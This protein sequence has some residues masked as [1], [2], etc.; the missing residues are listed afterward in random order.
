MQRKRQPN[1]RLE[2]ERILARLLRVGTWLGTGIVAAG[3]LASSIGGTI[4][5]P[6]TIGGRIV[7]AG[8]ALFIALPALR[9]LSMSIL[10]ARER[11]YRFV[12]I[13]FLVL[14]IVVLGGVLGMVLRTGSLPSG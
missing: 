4:D 6:P 3:V 13:T 10:F 8:I 9:V 2:Q 7:T 5:L 1:R 14:T 12:A 11:D